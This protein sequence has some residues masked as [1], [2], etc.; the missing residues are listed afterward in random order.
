MSNSKTSTFGWWACAQ[1]NNNARDAAPNTGVTP[2]RIITG[3]LTGYSDDT[4]HDKR[5]GR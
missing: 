1:Y 5:N 3:M 2:R 4:N